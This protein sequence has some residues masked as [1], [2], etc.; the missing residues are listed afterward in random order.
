MKEG[1]TNTK[2][3]LTRPQHQWGVLPIT[4][5]HPPP[6]RLPLSVL[7]GT[8]FPGFILHLNILSIIS[9]TH[10]QEHRHLLFPSKKTE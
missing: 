10:N 6:P 1:D 5:L 9:Q 3:S 2:M 7:R 4:S 8:T